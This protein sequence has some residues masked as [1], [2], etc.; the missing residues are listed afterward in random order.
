MN[1]LVDIGNSRIKWAVEIKG[2]LKTGSAV[3]HKKTDFSINLSK[4]WL[5]LAKPELLSVSSVAQKQVSLEI[6][7]IAKQLWPNVNVLLAKSS[8]KSCQVINAYNQAETLG[9]DRWLG[10]IALRHY[11]PGKSCIVDCGTAIT[12]DCLDENGL[13]LGGV[14]GPGLQLMKQALIQGTED[15]SFTNQHHHAGLS[16]STNSAIYTGT[17][18][19]ACGLISKTINNHCNCQTLVFTGGDADLLANTGNKNNQFDIIIEPDFILKGLAV[20]CKEES[21]R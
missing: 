9:V 13:H 4:Q 10:L 15:L 20:Y 2:K 18:Y 5:D 17:L 1:L 6:I 14:I 19:A 3:N 16:N 8:A 12:I 7:Q 11:Y 21:N